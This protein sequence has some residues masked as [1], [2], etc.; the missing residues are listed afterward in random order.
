MYSAALHVADQWSHGGLEIFAFGM[1][2]QRVA[3]MAL[4]ERRP[5]PGFDFIGSLSEAQGLIEEFEALHQGTAMRR[6]GDLGLLT[7]EEPL[8]AQAVLDQ[9]RAETK[10]KPSPS[11]KALLI[12]MG[13]MG[14]G[15]AAWGAVSLA[16]CRSAKTCCATCPTGATPSYRPQPRLPSQ[17][18][19]NGAKPQGTKDWV[20]TKHG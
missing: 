3:V 20:C 13:L 2:Q 19:S 18:A 10:L 15:L 7:D 11:L 14:L 9:P 8:S 17:C 12:T 16:K 6:V 4:N 1:P 5:V